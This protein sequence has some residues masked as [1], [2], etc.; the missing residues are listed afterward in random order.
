MI[1]LTGCMGIPQSEF[2]AVSQE[3]AEIKEVY[4]PRDFF[5]TQ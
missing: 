3:L 2:E 5:I 1:P 4:P